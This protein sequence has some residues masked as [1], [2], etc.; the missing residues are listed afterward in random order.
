MSA[1]DYRFM[2]DKAMTFV[3]EKL[4][5]DIEE[6]RISGWDESNHHRIEAYEIV[7]EYMKQLEIKFEGE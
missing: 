4:D 5:E 6:Q 7:L 3:I 1:P 2:F